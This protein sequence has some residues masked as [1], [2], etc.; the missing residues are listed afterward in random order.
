[1]WSVIKRDL[2]HNQYI[3][4]VLILPAVGGLDFV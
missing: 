1:M 2:W 3:S 4:L